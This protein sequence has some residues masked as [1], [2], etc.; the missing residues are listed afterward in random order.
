MSAWKGNEAGA[1]K[2][3]CPRCHKSFGY[4]RM[5]TDD[6]VCR[7]CGHIYGFAPV[8]TATKPG[9]TKKEKK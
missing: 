1:W 8:K 5:R 4:H 7:H 3:R 9:Q 6:F 2:Q